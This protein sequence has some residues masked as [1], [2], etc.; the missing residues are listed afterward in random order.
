MDF[1]KDYFYFKLKR[2]IGEKAFMKLAGVLRPVTINE[3]ALLRSGLLEH[4]LPSFTGF[5]LC[6]DDLKKS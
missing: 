1:E 3:A 5:C 6:F 4:I 2:I